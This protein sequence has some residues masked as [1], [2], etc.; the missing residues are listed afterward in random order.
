MATDPSA[1]RRIDIRLVHNGVPPGTPLE[2]RFRFGLQDAKGEVH[3]GITQPGTV[4]NLD[5]ALEVTEGEAGQPVFRG[6]FAHGPPAGRFLYV[7]WK[8]EGD[9]VQIPTEGGHLFRLDAGHR[10]DLKPATI[11]I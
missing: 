9:H 11:P 4:R 1:K 5:L 2:E 7:G 6:A 8:R 3:P 10:S